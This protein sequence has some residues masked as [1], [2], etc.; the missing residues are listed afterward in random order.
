MTLTDQELE[1]LAVER[2]NSSDKR[3]VISLRDMQE[4]YATKG[5]DSTLVDL[6]NEIQERAQY[7]K[8]KTLADGTIVGLGDLAFT[9][10]IYF[11]VDLC[12]HA[13]RFCFDPRW[14]A[15]EEFD[16]LTDGDTYPTG[17]IATRPE[18]I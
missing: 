5:P 14:R 8:I 7:I 15:D 13:K 2:L 16:K 4:I 12:G 9:R 3:K 18:P 17:W 10:A 1:A 11:D 6:E